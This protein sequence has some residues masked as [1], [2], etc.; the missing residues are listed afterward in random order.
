M[1][2]EKLLPLLL[3]NRALNKAQEKALDNVYKEIAAMNTDSRDAEDWFILGYLELKEEHADEALDM[4]DR[5]IKLLPEFEA[6]YRYRASAYAMLKDYTKAEKDASKAIELDSEYADAYYERA[7]IYKSLYEWDKALTDCDKVMELEEDHLHA[8]LLKAK[9]HYDATSYEEAIV[10]Y[11]DVL[12]EDPKNADALSS[13]GLAYFFNN[14]YEEA[15]ADIKKAKVVE[16][17]SLVF[18]FNIGIICCAIPERSKEA[19]R[20]LEKAFKKDGNLLMNYIE[21]ADKKEAARLIGKLNI[22]FE[23]VK[24]RKDEN[25]YTRELYELLNRKLKNANEALNEGV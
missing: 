7:F 15:L 18:E 17:A 12:K 4:F 25:F 22:L 14:Q 8:I 19:F 1:T 9:V 20:H 24:N 21:Y 10:S 11:T 3:S 13:R 16:G 6:A 23:A 5:S 2:K